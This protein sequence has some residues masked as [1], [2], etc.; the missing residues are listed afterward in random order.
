[1]D[2]RPCMPS[3][4]DGAALASRQPHA[5]LVMQQTST[6]ALKISK[7]IGIKQEAE[8]REEAEAKA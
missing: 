8:Q 4:F 5:D 3:P 2:G 1:M 6:A 7:K